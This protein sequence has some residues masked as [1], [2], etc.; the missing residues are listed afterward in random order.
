MTDLSRWGQYERVKKWSFRDRYLLWA[1]L[2]NTHT[3]EQMRREYFAIAPYQSES[4]P[5]QIN[6]KL[7]YRR[8]D[9]VRTPNKRR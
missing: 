3:I 6:T 5:F 1:E 4:E 8:A 7:L 9:T 2:K